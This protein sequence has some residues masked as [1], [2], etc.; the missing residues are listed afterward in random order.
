M[1][2]PSKT[3]LS[4]MPAQWSK[5]SILFKVRSVIRSL[6]SRLANSL[7]YSLAD[8]DWEAKACQQFFDAASVLKCCGTPELTLTAYVKLGVVDGASG[9]GSV[10]IKLAFNMTQLQNFLT[11]LASA[12]MNNT[13]MFLKPL[14]DGSTLEVRYIIRMSSSFQLSLF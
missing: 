3:P 4:S 13:K 5:A 9:S 14:P 12:I 1:I 7:K 2:E 6:L 10:Q 8:E 11:R